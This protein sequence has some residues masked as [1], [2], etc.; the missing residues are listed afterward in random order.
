MYRIRRFGVVRTATV[1][2]V[3]YAIAVAIVMVPIVLIVIATGTPREQ[4]ALAGIGVAFALFAAL[5]LLV[6]Y[7]LLVW[8]FTAIACLA[9]NVAARWVGGIVVEVER[10]AGALPGAE[11]PW[12]APGPPPSWGNPPAGPAWP[13]DRR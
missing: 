10:P 7:P 8:V 3:A 11:P 5:I 6:I 4:G 9:Y 12:Q 13:A 2:A 1:V